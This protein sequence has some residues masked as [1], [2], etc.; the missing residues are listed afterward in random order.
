MLCWEHTRMK[1]LMAPRDF[2][3]A[4]GTVTSFCL[5]RKTNLPEPKEHLDYSLRP[6]VGLFC[7]E[8][9]A[10]LNDPCESLPLQDVPWLHEICAL[11]R[12]P[13]WKQQDDGCQ[14]DAKGCPACVG[15]L[16]MAVTLCPCSGSTVPVQD[17]CREFT[18]GNAG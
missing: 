8:P 14:V 1:V 7:A 10:G 12:S 3:S 2:S 11:G 15:H 4:Q 9:G 13:G 5:R 18:P 16:R 6:R 17:P